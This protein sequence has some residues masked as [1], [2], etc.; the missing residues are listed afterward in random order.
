MAIPEALASLGVALKE[1]APGVVLPAHKRYA[2]SMIADGQAARGTSD[3]FAKAAAAGVSPEAHAAVNAA[4]QMANVAGIAPPPEPVAPALAPQSAASAGQQAFSASNPDPAGGQQ[5]GIQPGVGGTAGAPAVNT[6]P[7]PGTYYD[8]A[9][10]R[11]VYDPNYHGPYQPILNA[12]ASTPDAVSGSPQQ[13]AFGP[14]TSPGAPASTQGPGAGRIPDAPI[15]QYAEVDQGRIDHAWEMFDLA[16]ARIPTPPKPADMPKIG[17]EQLFI[18]AAAGAID[19]VAGSIVAKN[20][21]EAPVA[22]KTL[23]DQENDRS[24]ANEI[25]LW[26]NET[27]RLG[28]SAQ[29]IEQSEVN[30]ANTKQRSLDT[31]Y[32]R[33]TISRDKALGQ[34]GAG[35]RRVEQDLSKQITKIQDI[36]TSRPLDPA[37]RAQ[38]TAQL[39]DLLQTHQGL[40]DDILGVESGGQSIFFDANGKPTPQFDELQ[41]KITLIDERGKTEASKRT[42]LSAKFHLTEAQMDRIYFLMP[43]EADRMDSQ[44]AANYGRRLQSV[45]SAINLASTVDKRTFD[46]G[47][48][49]G[50]FNF[51]VTKA[52][53]GE[54][55]KLLAA[56]IKER[57]GLNKDA[58]K[59]EGNAAKFH[60]DNLALIT[61]NPDGA[62]A[63]QWKAMLTDASTKRDAADKMDNEGDVLDTLQGTRDRISGLLGNL[64]ATPPA[65]VPE[66]PTPGTVGD[67]GPGS[68]RSGPASI[69]YNNPGAQYPGPSSRKFGSTETET[70]GGGHKIA[71]FSDPVSGAAAQ[72]DLLARSYA[73]MTLRAAIAKWSGNN[74]P[75]QYASLVSKASGIG[76]NEVITKELLAS[77]RGVAMVK[78]MARHEAGRDFPLSDTGWQQAQAKAFGGATASRS[79][80]KPKE[81]PGASYGSQDAGGK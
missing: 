6:G 56:K 13:P 73:G 26:Q 22:A 36:L 27:T 34:Q 33:D 77:P 43:H 68:R 44:T 2:L 31:Q 7:P 69:R 54:V 37:T 71:V 30:Q 60:D 17:M 5:V 10:G 11:S 14:A 76:P 70:I 50:R 21:L 3:G 63:I 29:H 62:E 40:R 79:Y 64:A 18:L 46:E 66:K 53:L 25:K 24:Y 39:N 4:E 72:F 49:L 1:N 9:S 28:Q 81:Q 32:T 42:L 59:I 41:K 38:Y 57:D 75:T 23:M 61:K 58:A 8:V 19:P 51:D 78:A 48:A 65:S 67:S 35:L 55:D 15:H 74:S 16:M 52:Q 80:T 45:W 47:L 12:Q 20:I